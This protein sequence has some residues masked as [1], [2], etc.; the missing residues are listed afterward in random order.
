MLDIK[1]G[2]W[3]FTLVHF[4]TD[5]DVRRKIV[6]CL[7][8]A[9]PKD[10]TITEI[11]RSCG[12]SRNTAPGYLLALEAEGIV[13]ARLVGRA[14]MFALAPALNL[15]YKKA[16]LEWQP[17]QVSATA[18]RQDRASMLSLKLLRLLLRE[19][20]GDEI[21]DQAFDVTYSNK[22]LKIRM[23]SQ[24]EKRFSE[25]WEVMKEL[26]GKPSKEEKLCFEISL[27]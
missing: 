4:A 24:L 12:I 17:E 11:A 9:F 18:T 8:R 2:H 10:L 5:Q 1:V 20:F 13:K 22:I 16:T 6:V 27:G 25:F 7:R 19:K 15:G 3:C 23:K 26:D 21:M 14:K